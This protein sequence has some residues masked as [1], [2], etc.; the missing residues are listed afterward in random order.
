MEPIN[1]KHDNNTISSVGVSPDGSVVGG[2]E[3]NGSVYIANAGNLG[4]NQSGDVIWAI[5]SPGYNPNSFQHNKWR[6]CWYFS[7][8]KNNT[9]TKKISI[10]F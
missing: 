10:P 7:I 5:N 1:K 4:N 6:K 9:Y 3:A 8:P 2:T